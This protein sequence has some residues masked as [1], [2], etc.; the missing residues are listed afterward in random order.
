MLMLSEEELD[1]LAEW[2]PD[3]ERS[4]KG[5]RPPA[6]KREV[7][8]GIFWV[9]DHGA[10][11]KDLPAR[12]GSK[13][14]VHRWFLTR[15]KA[16]V[17]ESLMQAAGALWKTP[18]GCAST[19]VSS[20]ALLPRPRVGDGIGC[21]RVGKGVK[22]MILVNAKGLPVAACSAPAN[23]AESHLIQ[24]LFAFMISETSPPRVIGDKAHDSYRL[25]QFLADQ[26]VEMMAP[27][28]L[29]RSQT[30]DGRPCDVTSGAGPS[31]APLPRFKTTADFASAG[32]NHLA[33]QG[34]LHVACALLLI[35]E[36]W[37]SF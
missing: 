33:F 30:Q 27:N 6:D 29:N 2:I 3:A 10:K 20:M 1:W 37:H 25:D 35:K 14:T 9:L 21:T 13:S 31:N 18:A 5:G 28:R 22:V 8:A 32:K 26:G 15:V 16:G 11:W 12:F 19:N 17:F 36:V 24:Q 4:P 23:P 34:F 7:I